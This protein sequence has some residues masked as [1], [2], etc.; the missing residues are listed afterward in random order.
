MGKFA[1]YW[2]VVQT[3]AQKMV[4][5]LIFWSFDFIKVKVDK[6]L[7][8]STLPTMYTM[9]NLEVKGKY[10]KCYHKVPPLWQI[11]SIEITLPCN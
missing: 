6:H 9:A 8:S 11:A 3:C 1:K 4:G 7:S 10:L 5:G 2:I